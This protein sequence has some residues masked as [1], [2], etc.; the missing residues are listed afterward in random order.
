[1]QLLENSATTQV[2]HHP[3]TI[4]EETIALDRLW[5]KLPDGFAIKK[6]TDTKGGELVILEFK[7][8]SYVTDQYVKRAKHVAEAQYKPLKSTLQK[9][10]GLQGWTVTQKSFIAGARSLNEQDLHDNLAYFKVLQVGIDS[11]RS[12]LAFKI[13]D[14]YANILKGMYSTR[15]NGRPKNKGDHDQMDTVPDGPSPPL[16]TSLSKPDGQTR[17]GVKRRRRRRALARIK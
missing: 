11:I 5:K 13:F 4:I 9:T 6:P 10:L 16:I 15:F 17:S 7:H 12:K 2:D 8:M 14:E 1:V 3:L